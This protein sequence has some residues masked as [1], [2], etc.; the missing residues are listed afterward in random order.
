MFPVATNLNTVTGS[1]VD[2]IGG[3]LLVFTSTNPSTGAVRSTRQLSYVS[4]SVPYPFLSREA[5][6]D[7][8]V[9]PTSFPSIGSCDTSTTARAA[10][11]SAKHSPAPAKHS[12]APAKH[13]PCT[14]TGVASPD[15][16]TCDNTLT[17]KNTLYLDSHQ[18]QLV[19]GDGLKCTLQDWQAVAKFAQGGRYQVGE[20]LARVLEQRDPT[21][22][23]ICGWASR[24]CSQSR[25][26]KRNEH[27]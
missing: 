17:W 18:S 5:C 16:L 22:L 4:R 1:P 14:N 21:A 9:I 25:Q 27:I 3:I 24:G 23:L 20:G 8:G 11:T 2:I 12:P 10:A 7:L 15:D 13:T 6:A 26:K 19:G